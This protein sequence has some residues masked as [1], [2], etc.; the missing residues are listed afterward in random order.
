M[1]KIK[2]RL[3]ILFFLITVLGGILKVNVEYNKNSKGQD[4]EIDNNI[5]SVSSQT[6]NRTNLYSEI[7]ISR[8]EGKKIKI[9]YSREPFDLTFDFGNYV[10]YINEQVYQNAVEGMGKISDNIKRMAH[11]NII[12]R[13]FESYK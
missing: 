8:K 13:L 9:Y 3:V 6:G 5:T 2:V 4:K 11:N 10:M 1:K 7:N 12:N